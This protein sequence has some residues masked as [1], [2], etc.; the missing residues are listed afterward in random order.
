M[1]NR[2]TIELCEED[3]ARI[4]RLIHL[5]ESAIDR[6][7]ERIGISAPDTT[8]D[9]IKAKL[10]VIVANAAKQKTEEPAETTA[11]AP[12]EATKAAPP[13]EDT[14]P[15]EEKPTAA[16]NEPAPTAPSVTLDQIQQK[17]VQLCACEGVTDADII[18][19][20]KAQVREIINLYGTK[21]SDLKD[22]PEKWAEV[23]SKL[24]ALEGMA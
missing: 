17:V 12:Q 24:T 20:R 15:E 23:W 5:G 4:D 2:I 8:H 22:Q 1:S 6:L 11:E 21:V 13:T 3:R 16:E 9:P 18:K 7:P 10:S 19:A 14:P